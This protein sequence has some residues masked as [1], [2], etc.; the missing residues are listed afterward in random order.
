MIDCNAS[1]GLKNT[2][3]LEK[4]YRID[5]TKMDEVID[6]LFKF[7]EEGMKKE[8]EKENFSFEDIFDRKNAIKLSAIIENY[9]YIE[10]YIVG[11]SI[12]SDRSILSDKF[13]HLNKEKIEK[14]LKP[15]LT[16]DE[17]NV[18]EIK[19]LEKVLTSKIIDEGLFHYRNRIT[20]LVSQYEIYSSFITILKEFKFITHSRLN[21]YNRLRQDNRRKEDLDIF[22]RAKE[23]YFTPEFRY[24][25]YQN[26]LTDG[27]KRINDGSFHNTVRVDL[28]EQDI[29][30]T[31]NN[32][33]E[34]LFPETSFVFA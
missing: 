21:S 26:L 27:I 6:V 30:N 1:K 8:I 34:R 7:A 31:F 14:K 18:K 10:N 5:E 11:F 4:G 25:Y 23:T 20:T 16:S 22:E 3:F 29:I 2:R 28:T 15:Y 24:D 17:L 9:F 12:F 32:I 19:K 13:F 33:E